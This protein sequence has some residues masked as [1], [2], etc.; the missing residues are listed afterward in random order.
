[1]CGRNYYYNVKRQATG[2]YGYMAAAIGRK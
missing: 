1:V 2:G